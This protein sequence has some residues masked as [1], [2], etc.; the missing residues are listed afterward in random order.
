MRNID[1]KNGAG[2]ISDDDGVSGSEKG[3]SAAPTA[4]LL[5]SARMGLVSLDATRQVEASLGTLVD[6]L[7]HG[8]LASDVMPFLIG[9]EDI[10]EEIACGQRSPLALA[11]VGASRRGICGKGFVR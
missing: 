8:T 2:K 7:Q 1:R 11:R 3:T 9:L 4:T 5:D 10:L 6:W